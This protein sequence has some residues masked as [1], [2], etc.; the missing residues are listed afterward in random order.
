MNATMPI[1]TFCAAAPPP[2]THAE[3]HDAD[4]AVLRRRARRCHCRRRRGQRDRQPVHEAHDVSLLLRIEYINRSAF[5]ERPMTPA[6]SVVLL[7][8]AEI[9]DGT[10]RPP[11][12]G[13]VLVKGNRIAAVGEAN[14][15]ERPRA[16][17]IDCGGATL[18]P[19][20]VEAHAHLD[21]KSKR[22][23]SSNIL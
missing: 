8:D 5:A 18:M 16:E 19:G 21:R 23:N 12:R 11:F 14:R 13:E 15:L 2:G 9:F 17:V 22:L 3:R 7:T 10:G 4:L 1:L 6:D 20:L